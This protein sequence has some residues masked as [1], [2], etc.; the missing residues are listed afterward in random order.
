VQFNSNYNITSYGLKK[1]R[2][3]KDYLAGFFAFYSGFDFENLVISVIDGL[4]YDPDHRNSEMNRAMK[5][6]DILQS[7]LN[8]A[9]SVTS[10]KLNRFQ[11]ACLDAAHILNEYDF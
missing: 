11:R 10:N 1:F 8:A 9:K 4:A 6:S 7:R 5:V 3:Y 2:H